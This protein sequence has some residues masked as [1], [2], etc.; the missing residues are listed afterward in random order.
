MRNEWRL[1]DNF[2][3]RRYRDEGHIAPPGVFKSTRD[4]K[5]RLRNMHMHDLGIPYGQKR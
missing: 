3:S 1:L 2:A 5:N 4:D